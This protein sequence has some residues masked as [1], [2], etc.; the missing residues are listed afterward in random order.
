VSRLAPKASVRRTLAKTLA[1]GARDPRSLRHRLTAHNLREMARYRRFEA[2]CNICG[3]VGPLLYEL[4]DLHRFAQHH[5]Q[6][7]RE[8]LR[9]RRCESK[10]RD[11]ALA[12]G[13]LDVVAERFGV[14]VW[15]VDELAAVLPPEVR[16]LE[17]D[18]QSRFAKR[19]IGLPGVVRSLYFPDRAP[20]EVVREDGAV[21]VDLEAMPFDDASF[22][23]II[24]TEVMEH[25]RHVDVA[26]REIARCLDPKGT[27]IFTVP[28][29]P[30]LAE[31][32]DLIDPETDEPLVQPMHMH[33][34]PGMRDEGIKSY[35]VFGRDLPD[36]L[37]EWGLDARFAPVDDPAIGTFGAD[38][39][40]ATRVR[41]RATRRR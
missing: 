38:L 30:A 24:T 34:D 29:D 18:A 8:T 37:R 26:H 11:R 7:L 12:A 27:Y 2:R 19:L 3:H 33:G 1:Q 6:P 16:I 40:L 15:T 17:T 20:G 10:M 32:W 25:V 36:D 5:I 22:D 13:L 4:P 21:N 14:R 39:W 31:T 23:I 35:R 9:C 28:Y 41:T